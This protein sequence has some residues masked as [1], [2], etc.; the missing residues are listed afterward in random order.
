MAAA[1]APYRE[2]ESGRGAGGGIFSFLT[3]M[4]I[5]IFEDPKFLA[6]SRSSSVIVTAPEIVLEVEELPINVKQ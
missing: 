6:V 1:V 4:C 5:R 2:T 3:V